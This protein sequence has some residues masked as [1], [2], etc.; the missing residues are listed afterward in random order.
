MSSADVTQATHDATFDRTTDDNV[1]ITRTLRMRS[2]FTI[3]EALGQVVIWILLGIITLGLA[4]FVFPYYVEKVVLNRIHIV[5]ARGERV[6]RV[7]C[8]VNL[9]QAIGHAII[10]AILSIL[11][12]GIAGL[13]YA[14]K[15]T[16]Y[17]LDNTT[18]EPL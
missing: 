14:Y 16:S 10:W 12:L 15:L 4:L 13:I 11:T 3:A 2:D 17:T 18:I 7:R 1:D 8:E 9:G 6:G 5:N